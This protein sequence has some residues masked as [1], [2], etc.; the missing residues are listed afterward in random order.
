MFLSIMSSDRLGL[1]KMFLQ[2]GHER[3]APGSHAGGLLDG[4]RFADEFQSRRN[5]EGVDK[6]KF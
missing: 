5:L 1:L 2:I 4:F 3:S 6:L